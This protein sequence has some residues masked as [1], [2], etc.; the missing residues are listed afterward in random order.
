M[1]KLPC[2][3]SPEYDGHASVPWQ[4][5]IRPSNV[6]SR[7]TNQKQGGKNKPRRASERFVKYV[8]C[9][10]MSSSFL[11]SIESHR[12]PAPFVR[13]CKALHIVARVDI[14]YMSIVI[15][16]TRP[17]CHPVSF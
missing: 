3:E 5:G 2:V 10:Y 8:H 4:A 14:A 7:S 12:V 13:A 9:P 6:S 16:D 11:Q 17:V 15:L 1:L